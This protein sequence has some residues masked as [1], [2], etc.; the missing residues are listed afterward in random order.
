MCVCVF[1]CVCARARIFAFKRLVHVQKH[2]L[3]AKIA[4]ASLSSRHVIITTSSTQKGGDMSAVFSSGREYQQSL[5]LASA[6]SAHTLNRIFFKAA[7]GCAEVDADC[8]AV[9]KVCPCF[10]RRET[11]LTALTWFIRHPPPTYA[12]PPF[13]LSGYT[14]LYFQS[15]QISLNTSVPHSSR[16]HLSSAAKQRF[17][18][19]LN[20]C[21]RAGI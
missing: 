3:L 17:T 10:I 2:L 9:G 16:Q 6:V 19:E 8:I 20:T 18:R 5:C 14:G 7:P 21:G 1:V 4:I 12:L 15:A 13:G 11:G